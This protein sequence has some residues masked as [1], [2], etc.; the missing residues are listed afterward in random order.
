MLD[1]YTMRAIVVVMKAQNV[2][3]Y[4]SFPQKWPRSPRGFN[5]GTPTGFED[6]AFGRGD[7]CNTQPRYQEI[8]GQPWHDPAALKKG[9]TA[10]PAVLDSRGC[11]QR[12]I[13]RIRKIAVHKGQLALPPVRGRPGFN[14]TSHHPPTL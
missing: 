3:G 1:R 2:E 11:K 4:Y 5:E 13:F 12:N 6:E 9:D 7:S 10:G 14:L 8:R